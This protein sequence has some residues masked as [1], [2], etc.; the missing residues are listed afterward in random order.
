MN[1]LSSPLLVFALEMEARGE[2][3]EYECLFTG[4][5]KVNAAYALMQYLGEQKKHPSLI[6]NLGSAGS[7]VHKTGS[8]VQC[9]KFIQRDMDVTPL[10]F[11]KYQTPFS[12]LPVILEPEGLK[13]DLPQAICGTGDSFDT[14]HTG[15][16]YDI[17]DMEAYA[18]A[19]ICDAENIPFTSV[20]FI[21]DGA[22]DTAHL[23]WEEALEQGAQALKNIVVTQL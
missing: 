15:E 11:S 23:D 6:I 2:F 8:V 16:E 14:A 9:S 13:L 19:R 22:D 5:G 3:S 12:P 10:G 1:N 21:S 7:A 17:V 18:L 4:V 20:K